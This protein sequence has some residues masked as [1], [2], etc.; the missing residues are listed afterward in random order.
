MNRIHAQEARKS[1][2]AKPRG[3]LFAKLCQIWASIPRSWLV[4]YLAVL[5]LPLLVSQSF[6]I[7]ARELALQNAVSASSI[8]LEQ[9][10]ASINRIFQDIRGLGQELL[11]RQ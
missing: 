9:T 10:S 1:E 7:F 11:T 3:G 8:A 4:S 6:Y 5:L 2:A